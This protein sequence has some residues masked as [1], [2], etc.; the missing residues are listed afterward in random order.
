M[1]KDI[2]H[3]NQAPEAIGTY[4]QAVRH[5]GLV[6]ISGQIPLEP[7]SMEI[8]EGGIE[9]QIR[10]VF[11]N[12]SARPNFNDAS[13]IHYPDIMTDTFHNSHIVTDEQIAEVH[14]CLQLH[15]QIEHLC[16]YRH[17]KRRNRFIRDNQFWLQGQGARNGDPLTLATR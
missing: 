10:R 17:I 6:F 13:K 7:S 15:H 2:L 14:L 1:S 4:S 5:Q 8:V 9:A 11:E 16:L 12:L 3:T